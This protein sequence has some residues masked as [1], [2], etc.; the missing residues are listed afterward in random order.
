MRAGPSHQLGG[1]G[2]VAQT[3]WV[4][5]MDLTRRGQE[6]VGSKGKRMVKWKRGTENVSPIYPLSPKVHLSCPARCQ[7]EVA[8][9]E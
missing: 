2:A 4:S 9:G 6:Q 8:L 1:N 7:R 5:G 3:H